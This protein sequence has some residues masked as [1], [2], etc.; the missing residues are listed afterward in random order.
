MIVKRNEWVKVIPNQREISIREL[1][2]TAVS[3]TL[4]VPIGRLRKMNRG[5]QYLAPLRAGIRFSGAPRGRS[6]AC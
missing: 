6:G 2:P 1:T 5:T 3:G 4:T